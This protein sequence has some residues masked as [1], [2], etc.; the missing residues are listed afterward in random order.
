MKKAVLVLTCLLFVPTISLAANEMRDGLWQITTQVEMAE[1]PMQ[2]PATVIKHCYTK[3]DVKV[4]EKF[5]ATDKNCKVTE[6]KTTG[7]KVKWSMKCTGENAGTMTGET[8]FAGDSY[9]SV[10]RMKAEGHNMTMKVKGKR[11][12]NCE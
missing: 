12:G 1:M 7:N 5:I 3:D 6:M 4:R 8:V 9:A 2:I 10:M 11:L